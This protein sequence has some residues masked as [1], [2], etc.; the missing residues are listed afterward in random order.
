MQTTSFIIFNLA[1][2]KKNQEQY[3]FLQCTHFICNLFKINFIFK[4]K[5]AKLI[6]EKKKLD[7]VFL[8]HRE[9]NPRQI[10][11]LNI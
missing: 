10:K 8:L 5:I 4:E 9:I 3:P 2:R 6:L 1:A 7:P 11:I